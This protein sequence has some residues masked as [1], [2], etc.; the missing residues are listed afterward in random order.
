M[1]CPIE[2]RTRT[3]ALAQR[4]V[5]RASASL[6][7]RLGGDCP[8]LS[9]SFKCQDIFLEI[10]FLTTFTDIKDSLSLFHYLSLSLH[11]PSPLQARTFIYLFFCFSV[12]CSTFFF[13]LQSHLQL[14]LQLHL[15][16]NLRLHLQL[17]LRLHLQLNLRLHLQLNRKKKQK[18][19]KN[20]DIC[21]RLSLKVKTKDRCIKV[22]DCE[23]REEESF[24]P[25]DDDM[26]V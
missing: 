21:D 17:N 19:R 15:Q 20:N 3:R 13:N 2:R 12:F 6:L 5:R 23:S 24:P 25:D 11:S 9:A 1:T 14:N 16:L 4:H 18:E 26:R 8:L 10:I 7:S 22:N